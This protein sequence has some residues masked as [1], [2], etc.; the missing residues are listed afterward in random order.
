MNS[1]DATV[2]HSREKGSDG[3]KVRQECPRRKEAVT[4]GFYEAR[5]R[6]NAFAQLK[7]LNRSFDQINTELIE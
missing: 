4:E 2:G 3:K 7:L 5:R 6:K 1:A